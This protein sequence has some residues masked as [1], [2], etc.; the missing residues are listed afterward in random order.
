M[1]DEDMA[2]GTHSLGLCRFCLDKIQSH[3][4]WI[5]VMGELA[6]SECFEK[7]DSKEGLPRN[8]GVWMG[9]TIG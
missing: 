3:D 5:V 6:H 4:K 1:V 7:L 9:D 2:K 8:R